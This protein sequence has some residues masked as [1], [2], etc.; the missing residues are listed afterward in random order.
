M[1]DFSKEEGLITVVVLGL[2]LFVLQSKKHLVGIGIERDVKLYEMFGKLV[3]NCPQNVSRDLSLVGSPST[4][5]L[6]ENG[7]EV[8]LFC[9]QF[10]SSIKRINY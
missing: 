3:E 4:L 7:A 10:I 6:S 2:Q 8:L 9:N 1:K 5:N